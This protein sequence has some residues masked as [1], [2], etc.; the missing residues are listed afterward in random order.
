MLKTLFNI[1][2]I[3]VG[4]ANSAHAYDFQVLNSD[5][6]HSISTEASGEVYENVNSHHYFFDLQIE[7]FST[8]SN[9]DTEPPQFEEITI[10]SYRLSGLSNYFSALHHSQFVRAEHSSIINFHLR[11]ILFPFH[12]FW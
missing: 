6:E 4:L 5:L 10:N 8:V 7:S 11:E 9:S 2:L 12:C 3:F 1:V